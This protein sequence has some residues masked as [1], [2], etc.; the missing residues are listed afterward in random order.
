LL[1]PAYANALLDL[2]SNHPMLKRPD[3]LVVP[4]P[5]EGE[6]HYAAGVNYF[7]ARRYLDAEKELLSAIEND[8]G[9]ARYYYF[10]GLAR[11]AQDKREAYEDFDQAARLERLGR[12][13]RPAVSAALERV[14]G[15]MRRVLNEIRNRPVKEKTK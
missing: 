4:E 6:K 10:L 15:P 1:A 3:S 7:F 11:L 12:P 9:D 14:Q 13:A 5:A 8:N 2:I